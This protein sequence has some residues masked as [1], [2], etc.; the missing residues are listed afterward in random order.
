MT[1]TKGK[2]HGS[3]RFDDVVQSSLETSA[4]PQ[5]SIVDRTASQLRK[6][7]LAAEDGTFL[8]SEETL[9]EELGI[10]RPTL[11]QVIRLLQHEKL[12][13]SKRGGG[14]GLY[15]RRPQ[16]E[17][18]AHA[19]AIYLEIEQATTRN[20]FAASVPVMQEAVRLASECTNSELRNELR[21]LL[22]KAKSQNVTHPAYQQ[23]N[24]N[25]DLDFS[26][27]L[28]RMCAN[29]LIKLFISII[30]CFGRIQWSEGLL[31]R[32]HKQLDDV[33]RTRNMII[34]SVLDGDAELAM[35]YSQRRAK[36]I[37]ALID[38][39]SHE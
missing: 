21:L 37:F 36:M 7:I 2:V 24:W 27:I 38:D 32:Y 35:L 8:G 14:G 28:G 13:V 20:I 9:Q 22:E 19:A 4:S 25:I 15:T 23:K 18:V 26:D 12:L 30:Y 11:R 10:S 3:P 17:A 34:Q 6:V 33:W 16:I 29:P 31:V 1:K 5:S 39:I